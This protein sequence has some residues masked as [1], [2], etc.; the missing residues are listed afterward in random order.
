MFVDLPEGQL[1]YEVI[2]QTAPWQVEPETIIFMH[3]VGARHDMWMAW[4]PA[5][6]DK[7]R[8]ILIGTRGCGHSA[9]IANDAESRTVSTAFFTRTINLLRGCSLN[10]WGGTGSRAV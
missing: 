6:V 7:Y 9:E 4:L 2:D 3:G 1:F 8:I 10:S 5:L